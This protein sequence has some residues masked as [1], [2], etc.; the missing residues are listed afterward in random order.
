MRPEPSP[1]CASQTSGGLWRRAS[2]AATVAGR[3]VGRRA[4]MC[5]IAGIVPTGRSQVPERPRLERMIHALRHRG[6]DG[7][8]FHAEPGV[9]LAHARLS[10]ID[11]ETGGQPIR[12]ETATIW[13]VFNG[14]IFNYVE[15]R[16]RLEGVGHSF[17]TQSDTEVLVHAY[18][19]YGLDFVD[20]LNGQFAIALWDSPRRR[21]VLARDRVGIRP[22]LYARTT[23]GLAFAS[24]AKSLFAGDWVRPELD[25]LGVA[26]VCTF[27]SCVAPRTAFAGVEALPP[28]HMATFEDGRLQLRRY[29]DWQFPK[30][31]LPAAN[32]DETVDELRELLADSVRLQLR[33]DVPVGAYLSG[34][35]DS[36]AVTAA[37]RR[38]SA[39]PL[40]TFSI[41][42]AT[43]EFDEREYQQEVSQ[44]LATDHQAREVST[45]DIGAALPRALRHIEAPLVRTAAVP[46]MLLADDVRAAGFKVVLTGEGADE[47]FGGYDIFKEGK[48]RRFWAKQPDSK[49]RPL[50]LSRLYSYLAT[51]PVAAQGLASRFF[52]QSLDSGQ[53]PYFTHR[54]R[55]TMTNRILRI[56]TP[57]FRAKIDADHPIGRLAEL[58]PRPD[59][60]WGGLARDQ[61]VEA[62]TLL[63]GYL[64]H[65]QGDRVAM[66]ASVEG[67]YPFLD[68]RL[69]EFANQLPAHWKIRGLTEKYILRRAVEPWLPQQIVHRT[70]QPYRAPDSESFFRN[71]RPLD[72][73]AEALAPARVKA[74][75][76]FDP[77]MVTRL[78]EKCCSGR[79]V[80]FGD[81][82]AF[83]AV[84]TTQLLHEMFVTRTQ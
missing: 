52:G 62:H 84:L 73:V 19:Q 32:L 55:W 26:E 22:L 34:G 66:A 53:D 25:A 78:T 30:G 3:G 59:E 69:I 49:W 80:G 43:A 54:P 37:I 47:V 14:E 13:V 45:E 81:N 63:T 27:W 17:Y 46:L 16:K 24:E 61:Y 75:G 6:P 57:E 79:A 76:Y 21:L 33:A 28:G 7:F 77:T 35:L 65:A 44:Y 67:R 70:K 4:D 48:I 8:G 51:S 10:I 31:K 20:Q 64:L 58:A 18:E 2:H 9:G 50:L 71:G 56:M 11:L 40:R 15:L 39:T 82:V 23:E 74:A 72:Y 41:A 36:S 5:G 68:H 29:W 1:C 38:F 83:V 42:F 12:N 60:S